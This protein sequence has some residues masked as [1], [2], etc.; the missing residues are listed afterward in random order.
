MSPDRMLLHG[1][2]IHRRQKDT[3]KSWLQ[4]GK[5][6]SIYSFVP[7]PQCP[8]RGGDLSRFLW[9][10]ALLRERGASHTGEIMSLDH[11]DQLISLTTSIPPES[12]ME[13][14]AFCQLTAIAPPPHGAPCSH[15]S[16]KGMRIC[17]DNALSTIQ[18]PNDEVLAIRSG[19]N[20]LE[21]Q[22]KI[23]LEA[24]KTAESHSALGG[25]KTRHPEWHFFV[26]T[27]AK[28]QAHR[29]ATVYV[30]LKSLLAMRA[31]KPISKSTI[32][33][34]EQLLKESDLTAAQIGA[35]LHG[36]SPEQ[37]LGQSWPRDLCRTWREAMRHFS[38]SGSPPP[39]STKERIAGQILDAALHATASRRAG[40]RSH[41]NLS[42]SQLHQA[43]RQIGMGQEQDTLQGALGV[44]VCISTF[45]VDVVTDL[46]LKSN[47]MDASWWA[48]IDV[49]GGLL[50]VDYSLITHEA[51]API[52]GAIPASYICTRPLPRKLAEQLRA[53][54][55]TYP[56]ARTLRELFRDEA[57]PV[58]DSL[59]FA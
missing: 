36:V 20:A 52:V 56:H 12:G 32:G 48:Q 53:R 9:R 4:P 41:R 26:C 1:D 58:H 24:N 23:T 13:R 16:V 31:G 35:L 21:S 38:S 42:K 14:G 8:R 51:S 6:V 7:S 15:N 55:A 57:V 54:A 46:R 30:G 5:R 27:G 44:L 43:L 11:T 49:E 45:S 50:T 22:L 47:S 10:W 29:L 40:A 59:V 3:R 17:I 2:P 18:S 39:P 34:A 33:N 25:T 37:T 19:F 28:K